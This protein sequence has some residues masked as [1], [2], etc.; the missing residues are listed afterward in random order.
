[1]KT[2]WYMLMCGVRAVIDYCEW[3]ISDCMDCYTKK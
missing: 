3:F 1:M 2:L